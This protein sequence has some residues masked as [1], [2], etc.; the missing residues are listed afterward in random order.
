MRVAFP[1]AVFGRKNI[2][3]KSWSPSSSVSRTLFD[4]MYVEQAPVACYPKG[5]NSPEVASSTASS[6]SSHGCAFGGMQY[7]PVGVTSETG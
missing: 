1:L 2:E 5:P 7:R 3:N 4:E 6:Y